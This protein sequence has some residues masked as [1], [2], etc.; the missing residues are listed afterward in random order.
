MTRTEANESGWAALVFGAVIL[1]AALGMTSRPRETLDA[2]RRL[3]RGGRAVPGWARGTADRGTTRA[4]GLLV[5][6]IG[7]GLILLGAS[8]LFATHL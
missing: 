3:V 7:A 8:L 5:A 4:I 2:L 1:M 6:T